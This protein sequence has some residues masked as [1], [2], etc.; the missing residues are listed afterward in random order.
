MNTSYMANRLLPLETVRVPNGVDPDLAEIEAQ[1]SSARRLILLG[2][3][4]PGRTDFEAIRRFALRKEFEEVVIGA[5]GTSKKMAG[6]VRELTATCGSRLQVHPW[7]PPAELGR[8]VGDRT[9]L[10][11]R[12]VVSDYTLSQDLL[13]VYQGLALGA[14]VICPR[15]LWPELVDASF[16]LLIDRGVDLDLVLADRLDSGASDARL[17]TALRRSTLVDRSRRD[18]RRGTGRMTPAAELDILIVLFRVRWEEF[19][20]VLDRLRRCSTESRTLKVLLSGS[21]D[22][23]RRLQGLLESNGLGAQAKV[24]HRFDN[25]GFAGGHN[26]LLAEAFGGGARW[27]LV[28]NPDV[29]VEEGAISALLSSATRAGE[30]AL[31]VRRV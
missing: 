17:A 6:L 8:V 28:L 16:G 10:L 5:P 31:L 15:L 2:D 29:L 22:D 18:D 1:G 12:H 13:K 21:V 24:S 3:F 9:A 27:C 25:L 26:R 4:F 20:G 19:A 23:R 14:R 30:M 7:I 11:I